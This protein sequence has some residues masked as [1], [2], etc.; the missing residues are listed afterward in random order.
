MSDIEPLV[1]PDMSQTGVF[2]EQEEFLEGVISDITGVY[3]YNLGQT[4]PRQEHV[5][6]IRSL[7]SMG[8]AR[9]KLLLMTMDYQGFQPF[10]RYMMLLNT[11]HLS[12]K[13]ETRISTPEGERFSQLFPG[14]IHPE[15]DFTVR[16]TSMEPALSKGSRVQNLMQLSTVWQ[17][18]PWLQQN[19]WMKA[20]MELM[21]MPDTDRFLKSPQQLQQEQKAQIEQ[22]AMMELGK[23]ALSDKMSAS[24]SQREL[25]RD[26]VK[27]LLK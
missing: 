15:Y 4:P 21:D 5:G 12:D 2:R 19:E 17:Q 27:G 1:I 14:D 10:L 11:W 8:E 3:P 23:A 22:A 16:Y 18:S 26:V 7:Q 9:S 13:F 20:I 6:T 25:Q 24:Q